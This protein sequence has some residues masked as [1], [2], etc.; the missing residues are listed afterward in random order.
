MGSEEVGKFYVCLGRKEPTLSRTTTNGDGEK[1]RTA[2]LPCRDDGKSRRWT[3]VS[4]LFYPLSFSAVKY[5]TKLTHQC[6]QRVRPL[7]QNPFSLGGPTVSLVFLYRLPKPP[8]PTSL[9]LQRSNLVPK[10]WEDLNYK[11][12]TPLFFES[13]TV[14]SVRK[15]TTHSN[16]S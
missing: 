6:F 4:L 13:P 10:V 3:P 1:E 8:T 14:P 9:P 2:H 15:E 7:P 12:K 16:P 11:R 5:T